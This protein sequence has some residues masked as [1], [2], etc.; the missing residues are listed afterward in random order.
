MRILIASTAF[1]ETAAVLR[2]RLPA[3][4]IVV[5]AGRAEGSFDVIVPLMSRVGAE[6][7]DR[8]RPRLI[9]QYGV[10]LE[11]V[12]RIAARERGIPVSNVPAA[13]TGNADGVG[14]V[15]LMLLLALTRRYPESVV[16]LR[17]G[18]WGMPTGNA[19]SGS[20]VVVLGLG[21]VGAA[22]AWRLAGFGVELIGAGT[23]EG[24]AADEVR[25]RL[26]LA[27]Y[28]PVAELAQA[29]DGALALVACCVLNDAT[30]GVIGREVLAALGRGGP[31]YVVNVSRG[32]V[33]DYDAL[34]RALRDE[35]IAGAGLDVYWDE[36]VDPED[37]ILEHNVVATPHIGGSTTEAYRAM[38]A[39]VVAN[40][41]RLRRGDPV[42][43]A[44]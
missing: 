22:V 10:G 38:G 35:V 23:R 28:V 21:A 2:E 15:A 8:H 3:D 36:P 1:P 42:V 27:R 14:E 32:P 30:R 17:E 41:E 19:L 29:C 25:E 9:Q 20:R 37:P 13:D 31:G 43:T 18:C 6:L 11:G 44:G 5:E 34:H 7:M 12:D 26:G 4:E 40:V 39:A 24:A 33:L 16:S